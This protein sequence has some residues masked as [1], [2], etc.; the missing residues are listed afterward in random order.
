MVC[1]GLRVQA[2][3]IVE[4]FEV[5]TSNGTVVMMGGVAQNGWDSTGHAKVDATYDNAVKA[6]TTFA[7]DNTGP[8]VITSID[9]YPFVR[10]IGMQN[11]ISK[12]T[13]T[14]IH[15]R[16]HTFASE[17]ICMRLTL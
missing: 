14:Y 17:N 12:H 2:A 15:A 11:L 4:L 9:V 1:I 10:Q 6:T 5:M 13:H 7:I 8:H 3:R 16:T